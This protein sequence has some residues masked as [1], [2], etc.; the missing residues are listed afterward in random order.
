MAGVEWTG[1]GVAGGRACRTSRVMA[2][3]LASTLKEEVVFLGVGSTRRISWAGD[4][5]VLCE[6]RK[7]RK[8]NGEARQKRERNQ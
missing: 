7:H 6:F 5:S 3:S 4:L 2:H 8:R 1:G